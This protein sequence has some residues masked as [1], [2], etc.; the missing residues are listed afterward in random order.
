MHKKEEVSTGGISTYRLTPS[1]LSVIPCPCAETAPR[2][3]IHGGGGDG[4]EEGGEY[5]V[6]LD[7][8]GSDRKHGALRGAPCWGAVASVTLPVLQCAMNLESLRAR[9]RLLC[10]MPGLDYS[11]ERRALSPRLYTS[12]ARHTRSHVFTPSE[13]FRRLWQNTRRCGDPD[14]NTFI[15]GIGQSLQSA[16]VLEGGGDEGGLD[17]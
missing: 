3:R 7:T 2:S 8:Q 16:G 17:L 14:P 15:E 9:R 1:A 12:A 6:C 11:S 4:R 5:S 13:P 10:V